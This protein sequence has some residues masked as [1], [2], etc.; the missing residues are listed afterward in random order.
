MT[1]VTNTC[2]VNT[3]GQV[4]PNYVEVRTIL[5]KNVKPFVGNHQILAEIVRNNVDKTEE[6]GSYKN[7]YSR[8]HSKRLK[9]VISQYETVTG[10]VYGKDL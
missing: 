9:N 1:T 8:I 2:F 10:K 6:F 3:K 4:G 5:F 7:Y